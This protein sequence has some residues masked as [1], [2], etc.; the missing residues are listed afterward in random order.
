MYPKKTK[1][2]ILTHPSHSVVYANY[3]ING[4]ITLASHLSKVILAMERHL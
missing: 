4:W 2:C 1:K 3:F